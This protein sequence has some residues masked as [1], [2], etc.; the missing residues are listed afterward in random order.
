LHGY[1]HVRCL[2]G[3]SGHTV[4][5]IELVEHVVEQ[6]N[7]LFLFVGFDSNR[8]TA[9][10]NNTTKQKGTWRETGGRRP[11]VMVTSADGPA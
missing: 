4:E 11:V 6:L 10:N 9:Q 2:S 5:E 7:V 1:L 3:K 8:T